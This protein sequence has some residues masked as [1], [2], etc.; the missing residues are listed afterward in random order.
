MNRKNDIS[1]SLHTL[2][3]NDRIEFQPNES[4]KLKFPCIVYKFVGYRVFR[5][6][7]G[8]HIT[9]EQYSVTHIYKDPTQNLRET[10][11]S[12]FLYVSFDRGFV[13]DNL[14]HDVYTV[15]L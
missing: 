9:R 6:D 11:L 5:A 1:R 7:D 14:Y 12:L 3:L 2:P 8:R 13:N 4:V 10:I 15:Y